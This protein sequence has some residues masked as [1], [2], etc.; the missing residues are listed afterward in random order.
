MTV[1]L[2]NE[3]D[4]FAADWIGGLIDTAEPKEA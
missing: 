1:D 2:Y 3:I 4:P